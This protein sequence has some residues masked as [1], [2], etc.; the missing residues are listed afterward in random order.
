MK[1][2]FKQINLPRNLNRIRKT[3]D[4]EIKEMKVPADNVNNFV[5]LLRQRALPQSDKE[6]YLFLKNGE[7]PGSGLSYTELDLKAGSIAAGLMKI[8]CRGDRALMFYPAGPDFVSAFF[9]CL[10]AGII[11]VPVYTPTP[12]KIYRIRTIIENSGASIIV[13]TEKIKALLQPEFENN[14]FHKNFTWIATD[15]INEERADGFSPPSIDEDDIAFLQYTSGSTGNPKGVMVTHGNLMNNSRIIYQ[16][17]G[18]SEKSRGVIWL[19]QFHDMGLIGG[20]LQPMYAGF[21]VTLMHPFDFIKKPIRWLRAISEYCA[22]T[23]GAPN[24]AYDLCVKNIKDKDLSGLDLSSWKVA[25]TGSESVYPETIKAFVEKF[26]VCGFKKEAIFPCYGMAESTL[27]ITGG[28]YTVEPEIV[29][30]KSGDLQE[31]NVKITNHKDNGTREYISCGFTWNNHKLL[32]VDPDNFTVC[33][34]NKVGEIWYSG[35]C[36]A[37][38]YWQNPEVTRDIFQAY[39][40]DTKQGPFL[41]T[42]DMGFLIDGELFISGRLKDLIIIRGRNH[43]PQDIEYTIANSNKYLSGGSAAAFSI[44]D[45][46][47]EKLVVMVGVKVSAVPPEEMSTIADDIQQAIS[48]KH[49]IAVNKIVFI[50]PTDISKTTSGKNQRN[51]CRERFISDELKPIYIWEQ[52]KVIAGGITKKRLDEKAD[53]VL[54]SSLCMPGGLSAG[55]VTARWLS[56][57][58]SGLINRPV[59]TIDRE[60]PFFAYG[61]DSLTAVRLSGELGAWLE[62]EIP[63][64]LV[65]DYPTISTLSAYLASIIETPEKED[66]KSIPK[67]K[68]IVDEPIAII[69]MECRF[70]GADN[71]DAF[72]DLI[73]N[74]KDAVSEIPP[75]R[76]NSNDYYNAQEPAGKMSKWG[77]FIDNIKMFD[78]A[79]FGISPNEAENMDPQQR[80]LLELTYHALQSAGYSFQELAGS[81]TGVFI[82]ISHSDYGSMLAKSNINAYLVTGNSLG[83][84]ANRISYLCDFRGPSLAI[85]TACSSSLT[86]LHLACQSLRRGE[87]SLAVTGASNLIISPQLSVALSQSQVLAKDGRCKAFDDSADGYVRSEGCGIVV[88]KP[89]AQ[90]QKDGDNILAVIEGSAIAHDGKSNGLTAPNSISQEFVMR[91]ALHDAAVSPDQ[92]SYIETHGTG[93]E[94]GDPIEVKAIGNVYGNGDNNDTPILLGTVKANIGHLEASAGIAGIIKTVLCIIHGQIP[95]QIHFNKPNKHIDWENV[96]VSIP[97]KLMPW[98]AE[99]G[100]VRRA[101][102]SSFGFGGAIAHFILSAPPKAQYRQTEEKKPPYMLT[103][104][105]KDELALNDLYLNYRDYLEYSDNNPDEICF[106]SNLQ[107]DHFKFRGAI[108]G[109]SAGELIDKINI[110]L[111]RSTAPSCNKPSRPLVFL[112]S[113]Q[114]SQYK[115]MGKELYGE[116]PVFTNMINRC[117]ALLTPHLN[118][119]LVDLL[120]GEHFGRLKE[121]LYLQPALFCLE[122]AL[123]ETWLSW[124]IRP[125]IVMGHSL[126]EYSAACA[127]GVFSLEDAVKLICARAGLMHELTPKGAMLVVFSREEAVSSIIRMYEDTVS[128]AVRNTPANFVLSGAVQDINKIEKKLNAMSIRT[129]RLEVSHGFHSSLMD[130]MVSAF[131]DIAEQVS[132][133]TP[134]ISIISNLT[135]CRVTQE[136]G[137]AAYWVKHI[138]AT[139]QFSAGIESLKG[140]DAAFLEIGPDATLL[141]MVMQ[142]LRNS[143]NEYLVSLRKNQSSRETM[144]TSLAKLYESGADIN[145]QSFAPKVKRKIVDLPR[146]PFNRKIFWNVN[147][148]NCDNSP[149]DISP[150]F[151]QKTEQKTEAFHE[152]ADISSQEYLREMLAG[153]L[154]LSPAELSSDTQLLELGADSIVLMKVVQQVE[155]QFG[156]KLTVRRFFEDLKTLESLAL[157]IDE[158]RVEKFSTTVQRSAELKENIN[159]TEI[160]NSVTISTNEENSVLPGWKIQERSADRTDSL[161]TAHIKDLSSRYNRKTINSKQFTDKYRPI[162]ADNRASAGFRFST[163]ELLYPIVSEKAAGSRIWDIND[164]EYIDITMGFGSVIFGHSPDFVTNAIKEQLDKGMHIGPQSVLV[165]EVASLITELTG[166][167][168]VCFAN[169]GTEAVMT[170]LRIARAATGR[171]KMAIF[172]GSYHGHFDGVLGMPKISGNGNDPLAPGVLPGAVA[173]LLILD[174]GADESLNIIKENR[175]DLAGVLVEPVQSR[176]PE[177]QPGDFL[178]KLRALTWNLNTPLIFDEM[179]TGFRILPGGAQEYFGVNADIV[180]YGKI[181]GGG[182]PIGVIAGKAEFLNAV[183]GGKWNYGDES[184]PEAETTFLAGTFTKHP[185]TMASAKATLKR[186]KEIGR[187]AYEKLNRRTEKFARELNEWFKLQEAPFEIVT[188]GSLFRFKFTGNHDLLFYH[189]LYRS[190]YIWEGRNCF[191]SFAHSE[192]DIEDIQHAVKESVSELKKA[193]F[194]HSHTHPAGTLTPGKNSGLEEPRRVRLSGAQKQLVV[195]DLIDKKGSL[196][197]LIIGC[198][199]IKGDFQIEAFKKAVFNLA[200]RHEILRSRVSVD[201]EY[202]EI[203]PD[204]PDRV[205]VRDYSGHEQALRK[206]KLQGFVDRNKHNP[207]NITEETL[208]RAAIIK[209]GPQ[210]YIVTLSLHHII[211][212]GWSLNVILDEIRDLYLEETKGVTINLPEAFPFSHYLTWLEQQQKSAEWEDHEKYFLK[213]FGDEPMFLD[214]PVD[215]PKSAGRRFEAGR[216]V[217]EIS[218]SE[219]PALKDFCKKNGYTLFMVLLSFF[220]LLLARLTGQERLVVGVPVHGRNLKG[221]EKCIGYFS[222]IM[223]VQSFYNGDSSC[224]EYISSLKEQLFTSYDHQ[225][226]PYSLLLDKIKAQSPA[227][228]SRF[229]NTIFNLDLP[230][231]DFSIGDLEVEVIEEPPQYRH[232]DLTMNIVEQK[233]SLYICMD[234]RTELFKKETIS[235]FLSYYHNIWKDILKDENKKIKDINIL[236]TRE[237]ERILFGWNDTSR[238]YPKGK[239]IHQLFEEQAEKTPDNTALVFEEEIVTYSQLNQKANQLAFY[240]M[241]QGVTSETLAAIYL[242]R[243]VEM[244]V[245]LLG[246][247]KADGAYVPLASDYPVERLA[248]MIKDSSAR[249]II[250]RTPLMSGFPECSSKIICLSKDRPDIENK[251]KTNPKAFVNENNPAYVIY[252]SGSTG[253]PKG[254]LIE[255]KGVCNLISQQIYD[256]GIC[257]KDNVLQFASFSFDAACSEIFMALCSGAKLVLSHQDKLGS[258]EDLSSVINRNSITAV[259][260]P[261]AMLTILNPDFPSLKT[262]ISAGEPCSLELVQKW[263]GNVRFINAYGPTENTVCATTF[264]CNIKNTEAPAVGRPI[265]NVKTYILDKYL[266]PVPPGVCGELHLGGTGLARGYLNQQQLTQDRFIA[267]PFAAD[268]ASRLYKTGDLAKY[269]TDGNIVFLGRMDEQVKIRGF[270]VEPA[271]IVSVIN[272]EV[273]IKECFVHVIPDKNGNNRLIAYLVLKNKEEFNPEILRKNIGARLP[274]YMVPSAYVILD[275]IPLTKNGKVDKKALPG[276]EDHLVKSQKYVEPESKEERILTGI[277]SDVL[278]VKRIGILDNFFELGGD[279][280]LAIQ[281]VSRANQAALSLRPKD[282]FEHQTISE[283]ARTACSKEAVITAEQGLVTGTASLNPIQTRYFSQQFKNAGHY[284]QSLLLKINRSISPDA[285]EKAFNAITRKHDALRLRYQK[286]EGRWTQEFQDPWPYRIEIIDLA[287][288]AE[289]EL[290]TYIQHS[291]AGVQASLSITENRLLKT[292]LI[293]T[294]ETDYDRLLIVAHH[295]IIDGVSWRII[296]E[297]LIAACEQPGNPDI[298]LGMKTASFK[299]WSNSLMEYAYSDKLLSELPYWQDTAGREAGRVPIDLFADENNGGSQAAITVALSREQTDYLLHK[300]GQAYNTEINDLLLSSLAVTLRGW[301][302]NNNIKIDLEGHGR[303]HIFDEIDISRTVG[304]F[305]SLFPVCLTITDITNYAHL[306]KSIKEQLRKIPGRGIGYGILRYLRKDTS[307]ILISETEPEIVF[308]YLGQ[309]DN[310]LSGSDLF[311]LAKESAG[312][313][314]GPQNHRTHLI[315]INASVMSGQLKIDWLYSKNRHHHSTIAKLADNYIFTLNQIINHCL[316]PGSKGYTPSDFALIDLDQKTIDRVLNP[317]LELV[318]STSTELNTTI[319]SKQHQFENIYP[320]SPM[321]E[322]MLFHSLLSP[323]SEV[324]VEQLHCRIKGP[325]DIDAF[326]QAWRHI[327]DNH[328]IFRTSFVY[329][330]VPKPLQRV[331]CKASCGIELIDYSN[332][333]P[334]EQQENLAGFL[335]KDRQNGFDF[336]K[337]PLMRLYL[338]KMADDDH[339][340]VWTHHHILLD[341]W[342]LPVVIE[343]LLFIYE[344]LC[345]GNPV[346][347]QPADRF[348]RFIEYLSSIDRQSAEIFWKKYLAG[349]SSPTKLCMGNSEYSADAADNYDQQVLTFSSFMTTALQNLAKGRSLTIN[350]IIQGVWALLLHRYSQETDVVFGI[351]TSG[352]PAGLPDVER[353]VGLFINTVPLR[354]QIENKRD[355]ISWLQFIQE[356]Q[357]PLKEHQTSL[358]DIQSWSDVSA[359]EGLFKSLFVFENYP[360]GDAFNTD[361]MFLKISD[362]HLIEKVNYPLAIIADAN[363][364]LIIQISYNA[365]IFPG[366]IIKQI[367]GHFEQVFKSII[368]DPKQTL[369]DIDILSREEKRFLLGMKDRVD[370]PANICLHRIFE[371]QANKTPDKT[372]V[373]FENNFMTYGDLDQKSNQLAN[374]LKKH[375]AGP[376]KLV[377]VCIEPSLE[378]IIG[379]LGILKSGSAYVPISPGSPKKRIIKV[380]EDCL[381][382]GILSQESLLP[383]FKENSAQII[384]LDKDRTEIEKQKK[385]RLSTQIKQTDLAYVIY[386]SG[387]TGKSKGVMIEHNSTINLLN[388]FNRCYKLGEDTKTL[389]LTDYTFD[390]SIEDIFGTLS[391]GG[392][393]HL[394]SK[395]SIMDIKKTRDYINTFKVTLINSV[396]SLLDKLLIGKNRLESL[397]TVISGGE[398]LNES[399]KNLLL[400]QGYTLYNNYG[401]TETTVDSLSLLCTDKKVSLGTPID[402]TRCYVVNRDLKLQPVGAPGELCISGDGL[403]RGYLNDYALTAEKF[404]P[405]LFDPDNTSR[406]YR[407]GDLVRYL[408]DGNI[409]FL[410]R[411]DDQVKIRGYRIELGEIESILNQQ[412]EIKECAVV[413]KHDTDQLAAY[414][415]PTRNDTEIKIKEIC[416]RIRGMLPEYM[417]P[418]AYAVLDSLPLTANGKIDKENLPQPEQFLV[419]SVEYAAPATELEKTV[420]YA[421]SEVLGITEVGINDNFFDIGGN[422]LK[423]IE[424]VNLL[425]KKTNHVI[426][427]VS[428][429]T[430]PTIM[431]F[432]KKLQEDADSNLSFSDAEQYRISRRKKQVEKMKNAKKRMINI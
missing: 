368:D 128:V 187:S 294:G 41:R 184:Y 324:Y 380:L 240:L 246:V 274:K 270:R 132:Y 215:Y 142:S 389:L 140:R 417:T 346:P 174:Y 66:V 362:V 7:K 159:E 117:S 156:L 233:G 192:K 280:I 193:G 374:Y 361:K 232:F 255:H 336:T 406:L 163:K 242:D 405:N 218:G 217:L 390:P 110:K 92:V 303:E 383:L 122:I 194:I 317:P 288:I 248:Y 61:I 206:K 427:L 38:G 76:F 333:I 104:S 160:I 204:A 407:T 143:N 182:M 360:V 11:A 108:V 238:P 228:E 231:A 358:T 123:A 350:T 52:D 426:P 396:P 343:K 16:A 138:I 155:E 103:L 432:V 46:S 21:P 91:N 40:R 229:I 296:V 198:L 321:Q 342:S 283:L 332:M 50:K 165:G 14:N 298:S 359:S 276:P 423:V 166:T 45:D 12:R 120:W 207:F 195:L 415:V 22:T 328:T 177:L 364:N 63:A 214:L 403:A 392:E 273:E 284:N 6:M 189:L 355:I 307:D 201:R 205:L 418:S 260:L 345:Q 263:A 340:L 377:A 223:P 431:A 367:L 424:L 286:I 125:D 95:P 262:I 60:K 391:A 28:N 219:I 430:Y 305:T 197:Y 64:T 306:I 185:L 27:I 222:Y 82:G 271:E 65:Y 172:K 254:T 47:G 277:W 348:E 157:Y 169:T 9:G 96:Q 279:S 388:W 394:I 299:D 180:T 387:S 2:F 319:F 385:S 264:D 97:K 257:E 289:E 119:S 150:T 54:A 59:E 282:I 24:F 37:K 171:K 420:A 149:V 5:Q 398:K 281:I 404:V 326:E 101:G 33:S 58:I 77:G 112:F 245:S 181:A 126:G 330:D 365:S 402:N 412:D 161:R 48:E 153:A 268:S 376:D 124:G 129:T 62:R 173:D 409:E 247:L 70:P 251:P 72:W 413:F 323:G 309:L 302:N 300:A 378:M 152:N 148:I 87:C 341:G 36:V 287:G 15:T 381:P 419:A 212:D 44:Q 401:P 357:Q 55:E 146:Y 322:G 210:E 39:T 227:K 20:L 371:E 69:G 386:T 121:T 88:L 202:L 225:D 313:D 25:F 347:E 78:A 236:S 349:F 3:L 141:A 170:A 366:Q 209:M 19:P 250:S 43:Y 73:K 29:S 318:K 183:D 168:R 304:W 334:M 337:A 1:L 145:W 57:K 118:L 139:V 253:R 308:N 395:E 93:T 30:L 32:I 100:K 351:T 167:E 191:L 373:V 354:V 410:G 265:G 310:S 316:L 176:H 221:S 375:G 18:H 295:L 68:D 199:R 297:D 113:G 136:I 34:D 259:T 397:K 393:L 327:I 83:I 422:S 106:A 314:T 175:H 352:R 408:P 200:Q 144:L 13:T 137:S 51:L 335:E 71:V 67:H 188:F 162:V 372:A 356:Q 31:G 164:N 278:G 370:Y 241:E 338:I 107:S 301:I 339:R 293:K 17:M 115:G 258:P 8:S 312:P 416:D 102:V 369:D 98:S 252:T 239:C 190:I 135:G 320:L 90:A 226:Y 243:S 111:S 213:H 114:G 353:M 186:I 329:K 81:D 208:F 105:A 411:I 130:P 116:Q 290:E 154:G 133:K 325:I 269:K 261:P 344:Q 363:D 425:E 89:L 421:W 211:S 42:G 10:Y 237:R 86:A 151:L 311:L 84:S 285:L 234:Y 220:K 230:L 80:L 224:K 331:Q 178:K 26:S 196:A 75:D 53:A 400:K 131:K 382:V 179:I 267:N 216:E 292:V 94:L 74:G 23:S 56:A 109:S 235:R 428:V 134:R 429:F 49:E 384:C 275:N 315:E 203:L 414:I 79:F 147:Q 249:I 379:F 158:K 256:F 127:A 272:S 266:Q 399:R 4:M 291:A 99:P 35:S 244:I 85:D